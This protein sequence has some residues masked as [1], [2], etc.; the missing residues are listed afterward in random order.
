VKRKGRRKE[1]GKKDEGLK[2]GMKRTRRRQ[3]QHER[4]GNVE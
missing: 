4:K 3:Q 1:L 2:N